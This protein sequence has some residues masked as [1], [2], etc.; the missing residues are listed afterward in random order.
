MQNS[1]EQRHRITRRVTLVGALVNAGL[2]SLQI[3]FGLLGR[4]QALLA[5][6]LH[7]LSDLATDFIVLYASKQA[8]QDADEEHPYG[9]GRIET[10]AS[11]LLG[12]ILAAVGI[13]IGVRGVES[14]VDPVQTNPEVITVIFALLAIFS[15]EGLYRYTLRA[16]KKTHSALLESNAWHHRSDALSS[17]VVVSGISAQLLGVPHMD[18]VAAIVVGIMILV[19]GIG[20]ARKAL[21]ELID[22]SL[23][24]D[25]VE[26]V[27]E[28]ML[29]Y[30]SVTGIHNLRSRS[31]GG[32]GYVDAHIEVDSDLTVSE[33]HYIAHRMEHL[34]KKKF[35]QIIDVQI[36]IDPL[37]DAVQESVL[38]RLPDR[39]RIEDDLAAAWEGIAEAGEIQQTRLHYLDEKLE[40]D[41]IMPASMCTP[42]HA[43]AVSE[44][45]SR[46][47]KLDYVGQVHIYYLQ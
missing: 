10:L 42:E 38:A 19:M 27:R 14:M 2:A 37:D 21:S 24:I 7:T 12:G 31:M 8:S 45:Q 23:D 39:T 29:Q 1:I 9:H 18:A 15:K 11:L 41:L 25:L 16:A 3:L 17:I 34:V 33:A 30:D 47:L 13:G 36:H 32:L 43:A 28:T 5:D 20:L 46:A 40:L 4:S 22:T 26:N 35:P 44:L 6:G